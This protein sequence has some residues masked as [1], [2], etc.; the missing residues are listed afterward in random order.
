MSRP[1]WR[2]R[3][4]PPPRSTP[5]T[6]RGLRAS[7]PPSYATVEAG[8]KAA[9]VIE[10]LH[11]MRGQEVV[12]IWKR[13][14]HTACQGLI[15]LGAQKRVEPDEPVRGAAKVDELGGQLRWVSSVPSV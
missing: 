14:R 6:H 11:V 8:K 1:R 15:T 5:S 12:A 3:S 10:R 2:A 7:L 13:R 9:E 4:P